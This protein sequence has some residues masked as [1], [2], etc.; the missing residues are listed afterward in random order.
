MLDH[1][2]LSYVFLLPGAPDRGQ[3][4]Q[5]GPDIDFISYFFNITVKGLDVSFDEFQSTTAF[6]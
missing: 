2:K 3:I 6:C 4:F 1:L 5:Q